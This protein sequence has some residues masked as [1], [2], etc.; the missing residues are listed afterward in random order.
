MDFHSHFSYDSDQNPAPTFEHMKIFIHWMYENNLFV[1]D[2][3]IYDTTD[4]CRN[5]YRCANSMRLLSV[6]A[7]TYRVKLDILVNAP[8]CRR[9]KIDGINRSEKSISKT[10][11]A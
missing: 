3:I 11:I 7:F 5:I 4:G 10:K 1:K 9:S 8:V 6:L 2:G